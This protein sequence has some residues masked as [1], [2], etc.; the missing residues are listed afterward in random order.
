MQEKAI[1]RDIIV[2]VNVIYLNNYS[3]LYLELKQT[4]LIIFV[5]SVFE[6]FC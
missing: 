4:K 6:F 3:N 5:V 2:V 1:K